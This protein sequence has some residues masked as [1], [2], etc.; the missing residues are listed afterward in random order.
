MCK[1][2]SPNAGPEANRAICLSV[3][4]LVMGII[5]CMSFL[6]FYIWTAA[7]MGV[8]GLFALI[9]ASVMLCCYSGKGTLTCGLVCYVLAACCHVAGLIG[10]L[11]I[12]FQMWQSTY[13]GCMAGTVTGGDGTTYAYT[14]ADCQAYVSAVF[15]LAGIFVW[16]SVVVSGLAVIFELICIFFCCKGMG[17][18]G[19]KDGAA[20]QA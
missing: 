9:G 7:I 6:A 15:G 14:E 13:D 19:G 11:V 16:P 5:S 18:P 8:G 4:C 2:S 17:Q 3:A 1:C 10:T 12:Y 20:A